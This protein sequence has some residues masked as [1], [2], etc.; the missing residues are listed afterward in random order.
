MN[1]ERRA[2]RRLGGA[3]LGG[4]GLG[5][6]RARRL[7]WRERRQV[8][9]ERPLV[10]RA[11]PLA[12]LTRPLAWQVRR[13]VLLTRPLAWRVRH[14]AHEAFCDVAFDAVAYVFA[15]VVWASRHVLDAANSLAFARSARRTVQ[16]AEQTRLSHRFARRSSRRSLPLDFAITLGRQQ[17]RTFLATSCRREQAACPSQLRRFGALSFAFCHFAVF[18][19]FGRRL[20][21]KEG[22]GGRSCLGRRLARKERSERAPSPTG[23]GRGNGRLGR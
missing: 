14:L 7:I 12:L 18:S 3:G 22:R 10:C 17:L 2:V 21:R 23:S 1:R 20:A 6:W 11:Q 13:L 16:S 4:A 15:D 5:V 19:A 8:C 9:R